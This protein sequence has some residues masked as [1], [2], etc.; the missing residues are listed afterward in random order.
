MRAL[1]DAGTRFLHRQ[2]VGGGQSQR[3]RFLGQRLRAR[4]AVGAIPAAIFQRGR[5]E[6][7]LRRPH[8]GASLGGVVER[9]SHRSQAG[10]AGGEYA[11]KQ[12]FGH[13]QVLVIGRPVVVVVDRGKIDEADPRP[14]AGTAGECIDFR[15]VATL[16]G[17]SA[18]DRQGAMRSRQ[19]AQQGIDGWNV[20]SDR[21]GHGGLL[22][23]HTCGYRHTHKKQP[24]SLWA[25]TTLN[26]ASAPPCPD[27][28]AV[29]PG[30]PRGH[31]CITRAMKVCVGT[32]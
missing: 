6:H 19:V 21:L 12:D 16:P 8:R 14:V 4:R 7:G 17:N 13:H 3:K 25:V 22:H 10:G 15:A 29:P 20:D 9:G 23:T 18:P 1:G 31:F 11:A 28:H 32:Q 5:M 2:V 26:S 24:S 27:I 30:Q